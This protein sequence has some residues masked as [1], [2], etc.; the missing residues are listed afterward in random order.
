M[1]V[2]GTAVTGY[3]AGARLL[4]VIRE[5][6]GLRGTKEGCGVGEC[7]SCTVLLDG[8][9]VCSCLVLAGQAE[10]R[11]VTTVEGLASC[12]AGARLREQL[13]DHQA[14]QCGYCIPGVMVSATAHL[15][16]TEEVT[17]ESVRTAISGNLCRCTGY[18]KLVSAVL[19]AASDTGAHS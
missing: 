10:G 1:N 13:V 19:T 18:T 5:H 4:D 2:N 16:R 12:P 7:G 8:E 11:E 6:L 9:P 3:D 17:E 14:L 15:S